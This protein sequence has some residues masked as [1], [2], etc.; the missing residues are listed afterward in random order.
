MKGCLAR[1]DALP[2]AERE[3]VRG[4]NAQRVFGL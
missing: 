2:A 1:V 3:K 4:G